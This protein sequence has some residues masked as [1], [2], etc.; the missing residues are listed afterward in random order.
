MAT[1]SD[2]T[3][4]EWKTLLESPLLAG[5]AVSAADPSGFFGTIK[6]GWASAKELAAARTSASDELIKAV[7]EDLLTADGRSAAREGVHGLFQGGK[8]PD[9]KVKALAELKRA[10]ELLDAKAPAD[11][12]AFKAW[13]AHIG[14]D[15]TVVSPA[16]KL[17][18]NREIRRNY[19]QSPSNRL[20][21]TL[22]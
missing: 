6:E 17:T 8:L 3:A 18:I 5:F 19:R 15:P 7:A 10:K 2:F 11:A 9:L 21:A 13:L 14:L 20:P 22:V 4:D 16:A 12:A 1:K